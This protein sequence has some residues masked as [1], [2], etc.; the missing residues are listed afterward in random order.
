MWP[1]QFAQGFSLKWYSKPLFSFWLWS[2]FVM[3]AQ[4]NKEH[5]GK[6]WRV[7][8]D[9]VCRVICKDH[10][11]PATQKWNNKKRWNSIA[12]WNYVYMNIWRQIYAKSGNWCQLED[13]LD[14]LFLL[15]KSDIP[16]I[17]FRKNWE[18]FIGCCLG[19][20]FSDDNFPIRND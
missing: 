7:K 4:T 9:Q 15:C 5:H 1:L 14:S 17:L 11:L 18:I 3:F 6:F 20:F 16:L 10:F 2:D 13:S 12:T 19:I 8:S